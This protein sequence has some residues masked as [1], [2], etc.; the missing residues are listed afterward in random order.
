M[1]KHSLLATLFCV[2]LTG[3]TATAQDL[4][5]PG[6]VSDKLVCLIPG[7]Y[8]PNGLVLDANGHQGHF[9]ESFLTSSLAPLNSAVGTQ[10]TLLP[11]ASPSSG[12]T[13]S[14]DPGAKVFTASTD[15]FGPILGERAETIGRYKLYLG[16]SYQYFR[17]DSLD[18]VSL[19]KLPA[20]YTHQDDSVDGPPPP[21]GTC[22]INPGPLNSST[23]S[24]GY[25]RDVVSTNNSIDLKIHQFTT[26]VTFGLTNRIDVSMAIP[27]ENVRMG[28]FS[29]ATIVSN[30]NSGDHIF[31]P[32]PGC[33]APC[34]NNSFSNVRNASGIGDIILR[35]KGTAWKGERAAVALGVDVRVPTGDK[36][37][38][39]GAGAAGVRPFV[40]WSYRS[41]ISP[42]VVVG[43]EANGSSVLAGDIS[44][45][46]EARL[47]SQLTYAG[48]ADVWITKW[49][50]AAFDLIGQQVFQAQRISI[51]PNFHDLGPCAPAGLQPFDPGYC[52]TSGP[53][54]QYSNLAQ[55]TG[56]YNISNASLGV[57]FRPL[58]GLLITG[59]V[60]I[61]L[62]DGGLRAN[63]IPL[64]GVSYTF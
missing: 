57:K 55:Q 7:V 12:I 61:R 11:L 10:S 31:A 6:K 1:L 2:F 27:I 49:F 34:L 44:T 29:N 33:P 20:V 36:L 37:N 64:V 25:V 30:S 26:F 41:R 40:V 63:F 56:S 4:C 59:N 60:E 48:G 58:A 50:T 8:G 54:N 16:F 15:S 62:N 53:P 24:C 38:F 14:W 9:E 5:P 19:N 22:S 35:V 18:G 52:A 43:Y 42:H 47:P 23:G 32:T 21:G 3:T 17:F 39:L 46:S 51:N 45:G 28:V 13:F